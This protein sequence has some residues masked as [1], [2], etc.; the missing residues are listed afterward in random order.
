MLPGRFGLGIRHASLPARGSARGDTEIG[1]QSAA[2][3]VA[4]ATFR[5]PD[6]LARVL[7]QL[8]DQVGELG[9]AASVLVVDNDPDG[10][11]ADYVR[12][13]A[14]RGVR[15][16]HEPRPGIAAAR[17]RALDESSAADAVVFIDDDEEPGPRWLVTLVDHWL[18]WR[19]AAVT[20]PV[21]AAFDGGPPD[22]WVLA[23]GVF[24]RRSRATGKRLRGAASNNLL[25]DVAQLRRHEL[26][27]DDSYGLTGGSD[28]RL[29]HQLAAEGG[30]IRWVDEA[31]VVDHIPATRAT[32]SWVLRRTFRTS[33]DWSRVALDLAAG[34]WGRLRERADLTARGFVRLLR[35][36]RRWTLGVSLRDTRRRARGLVEMAEAA[37]MT[38]G[39]YGYVATEYRR[40]ATQTGSAATAA[41]G[42]P[43]AR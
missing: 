19:C 10:G 4:V 8:L 13:L 12:S 41:S 25:L 17:N 16:V 24:D 22:P 20:G 28:T 31:E 42:R 32:R 9:A 29:T 18:K 35:G 6:C 7:P 11:A 33:N 1:R 39:A 26:R 27:F 30:V 34:R 36:T 43:A 37:G 14:P 15:Y 40:A 2:V 21:V 23:S 38:L 3:V 5:R